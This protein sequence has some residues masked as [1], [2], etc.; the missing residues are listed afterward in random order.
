MKRDSYWKSRKV[1]V[2]GGCGFLGSYLVE[3]LILASA[4]VRVADNLVTG[5]LENLDCVRQKVQ[6]LPIDLLDFRSC[7][8]ATEGMEVVMDLA[9]RTSGVAYSSQHHGEMLYHNTV[10]ALN[11]L[12]AA[13][14]N[15]VDR[16]L[17]VSSSC[18]YPDDAPVPTPELE[19]MT[20][21]PE[22]V[23]EG[24][25][26]AKRIAEL[27]ARFYHKEY[28]MEIAI[29]RPFNPY[30]K[31]YRWQGE[32]SHVFPA[33]VKRIMD[34]E[35]P[36]VVWGSGRQRRNFLHA[37]DVV[38]LMMTITEKT[39]KVEPINIGYED[40]VSIA[41]LV[42]LICQVSNRR[43]KVIFDENRPEGR[44]RKCSDAT[45]LRAIANG[46]SP[47]ISLRQ[48]AEEMIEWYY[49]LSKR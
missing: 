4:R 49:S 6:F 40:D 34:G 8:E 44:L 45:R 11:L 23:N 37:R 15:R 47:E 16:F 10:M 3:E 1:L 36:L 41:E 28:G 48:G 5:S 39:W 19:V 2:A 24:Y 42:E 21:F 38:R 14:Q 13:R 33:L 31:R 27:Q 9:G 17:M 22:K 7:L 29:C 20:H 30:G 26:W 12:E 35:D 18:V 32:K 43:P 25:G 46:Y